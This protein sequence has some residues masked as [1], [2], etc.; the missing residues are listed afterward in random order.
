MGA[1][2]G[3][4]E[5]KLS[6]AQI[7]KSV[8]RAKIEAVSG[9]KVPST[10]RLPDSSEASAPQVIR[11]A[12][13]LVNGKVALRQNPVTG[14]YEA[15]GPKVLGHSERKVAA[16][17][18]KLRNVYPNDPVM[19]GPRYELVLTES[20]AYKYRTSSGELRTPTG[21]FDFIQN[22]GKIYIAPTR[23]DEFS[24]HLSLSRGA[25]VEFS[26]QIQFSQRGM[27]K[28]WDNYSGHYVPPASLAPK[29][30]LPQENFIKKW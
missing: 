1:L 10:P 28:E 6:R 9:V 7:Q 30:K 16:G 18:P 5:G 15:V 26:G 29:V 22:N 3:S 13:V 12:E 19:P 21:R 11:N 27:L 17:A 4:L 8:A 23:S 20:G 2:L 24:G 14:E 25:D